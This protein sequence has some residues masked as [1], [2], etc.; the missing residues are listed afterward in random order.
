ILL[1]L[2]MTS[3]VSGQVRQERDYYKVFQVPEDG[4]VEIINKYGEVIVRTWDSD[5]VRFDVLVRA[6][7]RNSDAV[8]KSMQ[9]VE[10]KFRKVGSVISAVTEVSSGGG[11]FGNVMKE[12]EGVMGSNKLQINY[13]IW[14]PQGV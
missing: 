7:G 14:I 3:L 6:E 11:F 5:S 12:V 4:K 10:V 8:N 13:E 2:G 9:R 1:V